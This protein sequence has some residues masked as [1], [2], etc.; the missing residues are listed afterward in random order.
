MSYSI[1]SIYRRVFKLW[2]KKR[3]EWFLKALRPQP[4]DILLD[5]GGYPGSW[6]A[7]PQPVARIDTLNLHPVGWNPSEFPAHHIHTIVGNGCHMSFPDRSYDIVFS[8]SVMEHVGNWESQKRFAS[9]LRRVGKS[10]WVQTPA[11][12]CPVE[13]HYLA[14]FVHWLPCS[15]QRALARW[16]TPWGWIQRPTRQEV[17]A[18]IATTRLL[19]KKEVMELFPDCHIEV[20]RFFGV[21]PKSYI[22]IRKGNSSSKG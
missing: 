8:N 22:A 16:F 6:T 4:S 20:E 10:L 2:R 11:Y 13:P 14:P 1:H 21:V 7:Y 18:M 15:I 5:V 3:F 9:E 12:E 19:R 17:N